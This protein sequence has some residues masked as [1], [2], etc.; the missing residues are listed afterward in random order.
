L[1][2]NFSGEGNKM[3]STKGAPGS[4]YRIKRI[5]ISSIS[6]LTIFALLTACEPQTN[7]VTR[8]NLINTGNALLPVNQETKTSL[9]GKAEFPET[10]GLSVKANLTDVSLKATVS[11]IYMPDHPTLANKTVAAGLTDNSGNFIIN[12]DSSFV[13]SNN[14]S[15]ILEAEKRMGAGGQEKLA[16]RTYIRWNGSGWDSITNPGIY[17]NSKTTAV[18]IIASYNTATITVA[19]TINK[20]QNGAPQNINASVTA[21]KVIDV[22][23]LVT[24]VLDN[25]YDPVHYIGLQNGK[26]LV[27]NP[28]PV[29]TPVPTATPLPIGEFRINTYTTGNQTNSRIA[30][31][32]DGDFVVTWAGA[33]AGDTSGIFAQRFN[34]SGTKVGSEFK[35]NTYTTNNQTNTSIAMD[36]SGNFVVTWTSTGQDTNGDGIFA[37]RYNSSGGTVG[38]EFRV[39]T[40]TTNNQSNSSIAMDSAGNFIITWDSP[41]DGNLNGIYAQRYNSSGGTVGPEFRVNSWTANNQRYPSVAM[42]SDGDFIITWNSPQDGDSYGIYA[43]RYNTSGGTVG[44]E[45]RV[46]SYTT[47]QQ[48][49]PRV[50]MDSDGDFVITWASNQDG[51]TYNYG[52][53]AQRYNSSGVTVGAELKVNTYTTSTQW[54]PSITMDYD[55]DCV[56]TWASGGQDGSYYGVYAQRYNNTGIAQG[57]EF[58]VNTYTTDTQSYPAVATDSAGNFIITWTSPQDGQPNG[59][60][61]Q[62]YDASGNPQ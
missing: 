43:Q 6:L 12:P 15:F 53:Y 57:D 52:I 41:Q 26:Y 36:S 40:Y 61:A 29:P 45:F 9:K 18:A 20:I 54:L 3:D 46:N 31:D 33:G 37:Q 51:G 19:D 23:A 1:I 11:I 48:I 17:I 47:K 8:T 49:K 55:G 24:F 10:G 62:R 7:S 35:V 14:E 56:I 21:Q 38:P 16:L 60:Y 25:N 27:V 28:Q 30:V 34:N 32:F 5:K 50:A 4:G 42:D 22:A 13:P 39:N 44:P 59:I 58:K 2:N